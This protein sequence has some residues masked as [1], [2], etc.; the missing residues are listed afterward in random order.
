MPLVPPLG[1]VFVAWGDSASWLAQAEDPERQRM[2]LAA[3]RARGYSIALEA[4]ARRGL[5]DALDH[6]AD[7]PADAAPGAPSTTSSPSWGTGSTSCARSI[8][9][10][11]TT[12]R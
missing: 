1:S 9:Q 7:A 11:R 2:I 10:A 3:V 8:G 12:C 4:D 6:L 5:G